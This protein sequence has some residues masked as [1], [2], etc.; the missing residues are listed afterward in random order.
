MWEKLVAIVGVFNVACMIGVL[1]STKNHSKVV[2]AQ[3]FGNALIFIGF[4]LV[5]F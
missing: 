1:V 2:L 3:V 4:I 5:S